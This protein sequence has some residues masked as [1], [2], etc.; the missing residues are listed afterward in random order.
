MH[1]S[2]SKQLKEAGIET[3]K[4]DAQLLTA[5]VLGITR[6]QLLMREKIELDA[7]QQGFRD[8]ASAE[9]DRFQDATDTGYYFCIVMENRDQVDALLDH[10][11]GMGANIPEDLYLDGREIAR[12]LGCELP[13]KGQ[14]GG[15]P[16]KVDKT[17]AG[18]V[19]E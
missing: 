6:E 9:S 7:V 10:L 12:A 14:G 16:G 4:L 8:R 13:R 1:Q 11:R 3:A 18:M 15:S 2:L 5:Y 19:R 17:F